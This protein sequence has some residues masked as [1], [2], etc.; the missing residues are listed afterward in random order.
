MANGGLKIAA[1]VAAGY[2][3]GRTGKG[4]LVLVVATAV[5]A[6]RGSLR[7]G[8]LLSGPLGTVAKEVLGQV[9]ASAGK[10]LNA[11]VDSLHERTSSLRASGQ[12]AAEGQDPS[13]DEDGGDQDE[14]AD[15][16]EARDEG[17]QDEGGE[18][19]SEPAESGSRGGGRAEQ[20]TRR[21]ARRAPAR[22]GR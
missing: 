1:A 19:E 2:L 17:P 18:Q 14:A 13:N 21:T 10:A 16:E 6:G 12:E 11:R 15:S 5:M 20:S 9:E 7:S 8:D 4:R 3:L 22:G